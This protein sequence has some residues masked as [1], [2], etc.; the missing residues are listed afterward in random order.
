M[1]TEKENVLNTPFL[2]SE[3]KEAKKQLDD[4]Q[5][6]TGSW[7]SLT[8]AGEATGLNI[9][10]MGNVDVTNVKELTKAEMDGR[11]NVGIALQALQKNLPGF[12]NAKL[13][14][15]GMTIGTRDSRK[16]VAKYN[17]TAADVC[18]QGRF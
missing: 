13:R 2:N 4:N 1:T 18:E 17:M 6:I 16:I 11:K 7:A 12:E 10:H 9:V 5:D 14:N 8:N 3:F 15:F